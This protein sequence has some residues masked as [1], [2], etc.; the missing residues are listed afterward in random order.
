MSR[1]ARRRWRRSRRV[2][3]AGAAICDSIPQLNEIRCALKCARSS[4]SFTVERLEATDYAPF[5]GVCFEGNEPYTKIQVRLFGRLS[6]CVHFH[7]LSL[8]RPK[9][10]CTHYLKSGDHDVREY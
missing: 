6:Y 7:H 3:G 8:D 9:I 4:P 5:H 10:I 2:G 1:R